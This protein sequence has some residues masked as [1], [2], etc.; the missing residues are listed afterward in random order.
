MVVSV[1]HKELECK[2]E[3]L[4]YKKS[5]VIQLRIKSKSELPNNNKPRGI[6]PNEILQSWVINTFFPLKG[7]LLEGGGRIWERGLNRGFMVGTHSL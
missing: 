1:L 5:E 3:K 4:K 2:V 6:S 7:G